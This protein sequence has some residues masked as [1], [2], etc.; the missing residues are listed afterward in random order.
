MKFKTVNHLNINT[1]YKLN[2]QLAKEEDQLSLF[3]AKKKKYKHY[4]LCD[5]PIVF[6]MLI[7]KKYKPI[8]FI[9]YV[10]KFATYLASKVLFIEDIYLKSN[11]QDE[12]H[13]NLI[14]QY[15]IK[16]SKKEK[17]AR[18]ELRV[19]KNYSLDK[20]LLKINKFKK[21]KKWDTY[22]YEEK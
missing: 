5:N 21:I 7:F 15:M 20:K 1:L 9:I 4:F 10:N 2:K 3:T 12:N 19:L 17:Y 8:G 11:Y 18:I 6:G 22:R 13:I 16:K 14:L